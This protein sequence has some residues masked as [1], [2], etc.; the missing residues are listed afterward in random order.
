[1]PTEALLSKQCVKYARILG[2]LVWKTEAVGRRGFPDLTLLFHDGHV[3]FVEL[4]HP[5]GKGT[6]SALQEKTITEMREHNAD[7]YV[8]DDFKAFSALIQG[9]LN[10]TTEPGHKLHI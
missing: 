1:M 8:I 4:K 7:V 3:M 10:R 5:N 9:R 6:L 2:V